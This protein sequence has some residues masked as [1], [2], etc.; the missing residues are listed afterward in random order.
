[1]TSLCLQKLSEDVHRVAVEGS[2]CSEK[3]QPAPIAIF[4]SLLCVPLA[5]TNRAINTCG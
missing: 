3:L 2:A 1:M 4:Q 5:F